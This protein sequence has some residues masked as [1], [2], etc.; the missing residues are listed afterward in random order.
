[1]P[2]NRRHSNAA[3]G[4]IA[5]RFIEHNWATGGAGISRISSRSGF[6]LPLL[7]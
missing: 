1:M 6:V 7:T 4:Q 2:A 3:F 5:L